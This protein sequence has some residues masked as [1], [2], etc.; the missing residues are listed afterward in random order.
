MTIFVIVLVILAVLSAIIA[1]WLFIKLNAE[2]K[3]KTQY[4]INEVLQAH[5]FEA[6]S[7][8]F[9]SKKLI[10]A[11]NKQFNKVAIIENYNPDTPDIYNYAEIKAASVT[12]IENSGFNIRLNYRIQGI[13]NTLYITSFTKEAKEFFHNFYKKILFKKLEAKFPGF[14]FNYYAASD[15]ECSYIWAYD[16]IKCAFA[17]LINDDK[18]TH[19]II[20]LRKE[21]FTIDTHYNYLELPIMNE[22]RQ[23]LIYEK[24]FL[25]DLFLNLYEIIRQHITPALKDKIFYDSYSNIIYLS[26]GANSIQSILID[27]IEDVFYR[28]NRLSFTLINNKKVINYLADKE[29]IEEF[30]KFVIGYNLRKIANSFDYT[31][32]KLINVNT[33]TKF[34][35]DTTRDRVV[36]CANLNK[37]YGFSYMTIAFTSLESAEVFKTSS[38]NYVRIK[39]KDDE[40]LD[41]TCT[42]YEVAEYIK[43][44]VD[45]IA[46]EFSS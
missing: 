16:S 22:A 36:Y 41:V 46:D 45:I 2:Y 44:Q 31:T 20:N 37:F 15:W 19:H 17:Y 35:I 34:I 39:T 6:D 28:D 1:L 9:V 7:L 3:T 4:S 18:Q 21:F 25:Y 23:L 12:G 40:T 29:L 14:K 10:I 27:K 26:N 33:N 11:L 30:E 8:Y 32:D 24:Y 5:S 38:A 13:I 42:K 43:A